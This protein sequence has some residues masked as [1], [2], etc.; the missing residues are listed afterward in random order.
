MSDRC[1]RCLRP[2]SSCYCP[3]IEPFD[4]GVK[5][6]FLMHPKE[7]YHQKT[8]TGRLAA[9]TLEGSEI[10]VGI[11][12][13]NN[14]RLNELISARDGNPGYG[15]GRELYP[16]VLYP[17]EN[18]NYA[19]DA[20]LKT[21]VGTKRLCVIVVDATWFFARKMVF[22]SQ[23]LHDLPKLSFKNEYRSRFEFKRQPAPECLSTIESSYYLVEELKS[24]GLAR[25]NGDPG[26][27]MRVFRA[28]VE[29]QLARE[30]ERHVELAR[31]L[32]P[33]LFDDSDEKE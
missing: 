29:Y 21:A 7:A 20:A 18:A 8:G 5:F 22:L 12:F 9:L 3:H 23:N 15:D 10:I 14:A 26:A 28:M 4:P 30:Q 11:D 24:A 6:V 19:D 33:E 1:L 31:V 25:V 32:H 2:V 17:A 13:T 27:L 16:V